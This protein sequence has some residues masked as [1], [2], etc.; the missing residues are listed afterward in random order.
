MMGFQGQHSL[1]QIGHRGRTGIVASALMVLA[2]ACAV[3][4]PIPAPIRQVDVPPG[5]TTNGPFGPSQKVWQWD[6]HRWFTAEL[7]FVCEGPFRFVD[8]QRGIDSYV[9]KG[10]VPNL[11]FASDDADV[12][13]ADMSDFHGQL[14]YSTDGGRT[15]FRDVRKFPHVSMEFAIVRNGQVYVGLHLPGQDADGYFAWRRP[16]FR[17]RYRPQS[18]ERAIEARQLVILQAPLDKARGRIGWY[19]LLAPRDYT[20]RSKAAASAGTEIRR[21][22]DFEALGLPHE[23]P[24][25][26][27]D[28]CDD[29]TLKLPPWQ[30]MWSRETL[31]EFYDWYETTRATHPGWPGAEFEQHM[32]WHR[33]WYK[34]V[35]DPSRAA[36]ARSR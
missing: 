4:P 17:S 28:A 33:N 23:V 16:E 26:P 7:N 32:V 3:H 20:F 5:L 2:S 22:D 14:V 31:L 34:G 11:T 18:G 1:R 12:I 13:I 15:F 36:P 24:G 30:A 35:L 21:I 9:G 27:G 10:N 6:E 19:S 8:S 25:V 29:G